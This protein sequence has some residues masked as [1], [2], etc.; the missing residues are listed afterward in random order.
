[1]FCCGEL[2][3]VTQ[4]ALRGERAS[5]FF[6]SRGTES[7]C[8]GTFWKA[9]RGK[10]V[11]LMVMTFSWRFRLQFI[12]TTR[13]I[14]DQLALRPSGSHGFDLN[15]CTVISVNTDDHLS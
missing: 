1:M 14:G 7:P 9:Y 4:G 3:E 2:R 15:V 8:R 6:S 12:Y 11:W 10:G 13:L 5:A